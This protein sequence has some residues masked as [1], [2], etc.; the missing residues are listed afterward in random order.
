MIEMLCKKT[1]GAADIYDAKRVAF[2]NVLVDYRR[3]YMTLC[4]EHT[5]IDC[6]LKCMTGK[7]GNTVQL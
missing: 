2:R 6:N 3:E 1:S 7:Q 5:I 4:D